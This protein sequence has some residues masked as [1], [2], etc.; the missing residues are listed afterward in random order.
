MAAQQPLV[1]YNEAV[2]APL[3]ITD[4]YEHEMGLLYIFDQI[5]LGNSERARIIN[6]GII[7]IEYLVN[8]FGYDNDNFKNY[9]Q[10]LNKTFATASDV[11]QRVY[12]SP[13]IITQLCG[14]LFYFNHCYNTLHAIPDVM[15]LDAAWLAENYDHYK[16]MT[17]ESEEEDDSEDV[18]LPKF[19]G[20]KNWIKWRDSFTSNLSSTIGARS[21]PIEYI[22]DRT[23]RDAAHGNANRDEYEIINLEDQ[24][25]FKTKSVHFGLGYKPDNNRVWKRL[26][27]ALLNTAPYNHISEFNN[28]KD[29]FKAW[30][31]LILAYEGSD[32]A[33]RM[34]DQAFSSIK[35]AHYSGEKK[36]FNWEKYVDIHKQ[37][38]KDLMDAGFNNGRGLDE[39]T[40]VQYLKDNIK[41]EA[42]LENVLTISRTNNQH[43]YDF[44]LFVSF[45]SAEVNARTDRQAQ[46]QSSKDRKV[47]A[48]NNSNSSHKGNSNK[49]NH[50][51][52]EDKWGDR[53]SRVVE[54]TRVYGAQY[55][56]N[57]FGKLTKAQRRAV[58]DLK[59]QYN[60]QKSK[61]SSQNADDVV[62][63]AMSAVQDDLNNMQKLI[64]AVNTGSRE[65]ND[66]ISQITEAQQST[67]SKG[68]KRHTSNASSGSVGE[69]L[70][71]QK[72]R[73]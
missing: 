73:K 54:G 63:K 23:A 13:P 45:I 16:E 28:T 1:E 46:V 38:H 25:L 53:P 42:G 62:V 47:S 41:P 49:Q 51:S 35:R 44:D 60:Q 39:E 15:Q 67:M 3:S 32:F 12:F 29:G 70:R 30:D 18:D 66:E 36:F 2:L 11:N 48:F 72:Q 43:R 56:S 59:R 33:E 57:R 71:Q 19:E 21:I 26:K 9:L 58:I 20:H 52:D 10:N 65:Q 4:R 68:T 5:D 55:P 8:Q 17:K 69:F 7:S 6:D 14:A 40:K 24:D 64:S 34:R 22:I 37:A 61:G 50:K 31:A 27:A